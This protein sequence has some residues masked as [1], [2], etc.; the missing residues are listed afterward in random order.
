MSATRVTTRS[1]PTQ[2]VNIA[3][4]V[5]KINQL[6]GNEEKLSMNASTL[7]KIIDELTRISDTLKDPNLEGNTMKLKEEILS[8]KDYIRQLRSALPAYSN[9]TTIKTAIFDAEAT[10]AV[11]DDVIARRIKEAEVDAATSRKE[12]SSSTAE[13]SRRTSSRDVF[14]QELEEKKETK[15]GRDTRKIGRSRFNG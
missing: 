6:T 3:K 13:E 9:I 14:S 1:S 11:Y 7:Q 10:I 2:V 8:A 12:R 15:R 4:C 5:E